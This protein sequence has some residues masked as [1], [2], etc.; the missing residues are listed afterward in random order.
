M[1]LDL[2]ITQNLVSE[3]ACQQRN[4]ALD[5]VCE[6]LR[7]NGAHLDFRRMA[8]GNIGIIPIESKPLASIIAPAKGYVIEG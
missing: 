6:L 3:L 5:A 1:E 2:M 7:R 8:E 4:D